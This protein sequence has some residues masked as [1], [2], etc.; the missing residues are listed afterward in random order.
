MVIE[1]MLIMQTK[2]RVRHRIVWLATKERKANWACP[3]SKVLERKVF[4]HKCM[5]VDYQCTN[6][7]DTISVTIE[8]LYMEDY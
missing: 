2:S 3:I 6:K 1:V 5:A 8:K 7:S 4:S